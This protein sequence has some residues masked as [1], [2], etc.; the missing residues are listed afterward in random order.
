M[1]I[2]EESGVD[3]CKKENYFLNSPVMGGIKSK[4]NKLI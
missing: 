1:G 2:E 3:V 4:E